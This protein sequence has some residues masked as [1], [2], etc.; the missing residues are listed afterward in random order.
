Q[1]HYTLAKRPERKSD[2]DSTAILKDE[3]EGGA[4]RVGYR[5]Y[6]CSPRLPHSRNTLHYIQT[7][8]HI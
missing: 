8:L 2:A 6:L 4:T 3:K 5:E 1:S 7:V